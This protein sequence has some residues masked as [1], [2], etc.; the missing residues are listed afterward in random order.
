MRSMIW[1]RVTPAGIDFYSGVWGR[2]YP[3]D[4]RTAAE[5][6]TAAGHRSRIDFPAVIER[7]YQDGVARVPGNRAWQLVYAAYR[8]DLR[9]IGPMS[10]SPPA[11]PTASLRQTI[12]EVLASA[13]GLACPG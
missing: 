12:L 2:A 6:I 10:L 5:A 1:K 11:G 9:C 3:V 7:A 8:P 13:F 4:R